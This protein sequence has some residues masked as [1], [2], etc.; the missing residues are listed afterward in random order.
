MRLKGKVLETIVASAKKS[1]GSGVYLFG[2]RVD[3]SKSGGDIDIAIDSTLSK[4]E[5]RRKKAEFKANLIRADLDIKVDIVNYNQ[6]DRLLKSMI[7]SSS[8]K[9]C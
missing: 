6:K 9:L 1:F 7:D 4:E 3:D 5:F 2:S 8:I